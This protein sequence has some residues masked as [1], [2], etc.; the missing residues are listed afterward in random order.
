MTP[1]PPLSAPL[2]GC[3]ELRPL[4]VGVKQLICVLGFFVS[5]FRVLYVDCYVVFPE[6]RPLRVAAVADRVQHGDAVAHRD[7][8]GGLPRDWANRETRAQAGRWEASACRA[9]GSGL[10]SVSLQGSA[11]FR[12]GP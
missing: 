1:T 11:T 10:L 9:E 12:P 3:P 5:L 8:R 7:V 6:L 4:V 2:F